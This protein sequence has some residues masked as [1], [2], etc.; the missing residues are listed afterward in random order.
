MPSLATQQL[1][2]KYATNYGA[3]I[4]IETGTFRG[5]MVAA[6]K[7][8]F[9]K[10][11]SVEID[12]ALAEKAQRRFANQEH[13]TIYHGNS[14][15]VLPDILKQVDGV[16][17]FWL[18]AHYS[19]GITGKTYTNTPIMHE[20]EII[21]EQC[22]YD[23]IFLIDDARHFVGKNGY[24]T[25]EELKDYILSRLP[26]YIFEVKDDIIKAHMSG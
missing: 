17:L 19:G 2:R 25:I 7:N 1:V 18:D 10:I 20:L 6:Q 23:K 13:I 12:R 15:E 26:D 14:A 11:Y 22:S 4:L 5:D 3:E 8:V 21:F 9:R 24:P 16:S